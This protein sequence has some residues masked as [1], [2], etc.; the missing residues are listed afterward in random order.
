MKK[1]IGIISTVIGLL[2]FTI[3][4]ICLK[5]A[6]PFK[7]SLYF[8]S[9]YFDK[10]TV[11]D[12]NKKYTY[13]EYGEVN[14]FEFALENNKIIG[15]ITSDYAIISLINEGKVKPLRKKMEIINNLDQK[16]KTWE[17]YFTPEVVEQM[18][19][20]NDLFTI[21]NQELLRNMYGYEYGANYTFKFS[22]FVIPYFIN[23][24]LLAYDTSKIFGELNMSNNPFNFTKTPTLVEALSALSSKLNDIQIQ[25]TKNERENV[26]LGSSINDP[27]PNTRWN[28]QITNQNYLELINNFADMIFDGTGALISDIKRNLFDTDSDII[29]NNLINPT[30][31]IDA[32]FIY[33]GDALDAY[34]GHDNFNAI[35]DGDRLRII[36][37]KYTVRILDCFIVSSS[38]SDQDQMNLLTYFNDILFK[39][40]FVDS[41]TLEDNDEEHPGTNYQTNAILRNFDYVNYTPAAKSSYDYIYNHYF[42][43]EQTKMQDEIARSIYQVASTN[44]SSIDAIYVKP[45]SPIEKETLSKLTLA[46]QK[47][48]NGY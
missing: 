40:I 35:T 13:K 11:E 14:N 42:Y 29:L 34:Y 43:D 19:S 30:S 8:Y 12:I 48:L 23:D 27:E 26:V 28:T 9:S 3:T 20:F 2:V 39:D 45:I 37:T 38:I 22:D 1:I 18:N 21:E 41:K 47:K 36:R 4:I 33:N 46:F 16:G 10:T 44:T 15:G 7:P 6:F 24:K 32:A 25:W 17:S 31:K 5:V